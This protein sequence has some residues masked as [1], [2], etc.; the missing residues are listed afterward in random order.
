[1]SYVFK[2]PVFNAPIFN[3][4]I[5]DAVEIEINHACNR[6]CSYCPNSILERKSKGE[7]DPT[8]YTKLMGEL[9]SLGFKGRISYDFYNEPL[10]HSNFEGVVRETRVALPESLIEVY[11]N[12]TLLNR[13]RLMGLFD[14]GVSKFIVT[15][16]EQDPV[17]L[18]ERVY[19]GLAE[20]FK[21]KVEYRPFTALKLTNRGGVLKHLGTQ[22]HPL[23]PCFIP[24][25][26][27][28]VTVSGNVL[29]CF[30]DFHEVLVMGNIREQKLMDIWSSEKYVSFRDQLRKGQRHQFKPCETCTRT[31]VLP[32]GGV[33]RWI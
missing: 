17:H 27:V 10:L 11:S 2:A 33:S 13:E 7:I 28:T 21:K 31:E 29:P 14:C 32:Q 15:Q 16:H 9:K 30:E 6:Q 3:A 4:P 24:S 1:M 22:G 5:F 8:L 26:I 20:E 12:G 18:F 19:A 25:F 23:T